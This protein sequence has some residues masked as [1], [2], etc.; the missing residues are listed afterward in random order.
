MKKTIFTVAI[1]LVVALTGVSANEHGS[2]AIQPT[3]ENV[4]PEL[5]TFCK[6]VIQGDVETVKKLIELGEDVNQKSMGRAPIHY[7]CRYNK[8][9]V[10]KVL[11]DNGADL[12]K[13]CDKGMTAKKY[14]E[15]SHADEALEV[16]ETAMKK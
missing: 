5:S 12:K 10:L 7:A 4:V 16:L 14:A 1:A 8:V 2:E 6:A 15:L 3:T 11:I 13:R 9:E